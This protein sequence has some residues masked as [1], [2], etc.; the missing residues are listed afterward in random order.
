MYSAGDIV[1]ILPLILFLFLPAI[2]T[3]FSARRFGDR[4]AE[5]WGGHLLFLNR[6][7]NVVW[8]IWL[9]VYALS[10]IGD[11][12]LFAL[13]PE[14]RELAIVVNMALYFVPPILAILFCDLA[15]RGVYRLVPEVEWTPR[16]VVR[17]AI[18]TTSFSMMPPTRDP[19]KPM[20]N[21]QLDASTRQNVF[22][23]NRSRVSPSELSFLRWQQSAVFLCLLRCSIER[24]NSFRKTI[25][26][27]S[28]CSVPCWMNSPKPS[29]E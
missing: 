25:W 16:D 24:T 18:A 26:P 7:M 11:L 3:S 5:L 17:R 23:T 21:L 19:A 1:R 29:C 27:A 10:G 15:S 22:A 28:H 4:P 13:G 2:W 20:G 9:P 14:R 8:L 6:L 12:V